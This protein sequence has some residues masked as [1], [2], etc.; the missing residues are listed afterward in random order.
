MLDELSDPNL[1][2][3]PAHLGIT[4]PQEEDQGIGCTK[5]APDYEISDETQRQSDDDAPWMK[6]VEKSKIQT[7]TRGL[8]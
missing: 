1:T 4:D 7:Q 5:Q 6:L 2:P 3:L 8:L